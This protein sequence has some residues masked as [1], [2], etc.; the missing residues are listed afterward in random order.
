[1]PVTPL[2]ATPRTWTATAEGGMEMVGGGR[3]LP[4][5]VLMLE[6]LW[7]LWGWTNG[8]HLLGGLFA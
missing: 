8:S 1:M 6:N 7:M 2:P 3:D 5:L 4:E